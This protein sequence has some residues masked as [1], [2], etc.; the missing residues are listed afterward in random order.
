MAT[1]C[2]CFGVFGVK[3]LFGDQEGKVKVLGDAKEEDELQLH[4]AVCS[5][6][7]VDCTV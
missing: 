5:N 7:P 3:A 4:A 1:V 6:D 2:V